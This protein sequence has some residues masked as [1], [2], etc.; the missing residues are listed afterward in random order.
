MKIKKGHTHLSYK[1]EHTVDMETEAIPS[2]EIHYGN[3]SDGNTLLGSVNTAQGK[4]QQASIDEKHSPRESPLP[5]TNQAR[6]RQS[7]PLV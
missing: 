4:L 7:E 2:A 1:Q 5:G 3:A 6:Y